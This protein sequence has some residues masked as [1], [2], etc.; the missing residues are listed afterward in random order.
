MYLITHSMGSV[1]SYVLST[2]IIHILL[3]S[4]FSY[5]VGSWFGRFILLYRRL[6]GGE[7]SRKA[8]EY[9]Y[10]NMLKLWPESN[11]IFPVT[12]KILGIVLIPEFY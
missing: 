7:F 6:E 5:L 11:F 12:F 10:R 3:G 8:E 1:V 9:C 4:C 2:V